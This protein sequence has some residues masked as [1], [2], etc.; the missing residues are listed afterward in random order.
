MAYPT[1]IDTDTP[2]SGTSLLSSPDHSNRHNVIG[3]A[4]INL[5]AK[6]GLGNGSAS[7]NRVLIGSGNGTSAWGTSVASFG[8]ANPIIGTPAITGG[9]ISGVTLIGPFNN[10]TYGTPAITGG[11]ITG[12]V[13]G[14]NSIKG[15]T[16]GTVL[17]QG[18]TANNQVVGSPSVTGGTLTGVA[19]NGGTLGTPV[20]SP[21]IYPVFAGTTITSSGTTASTS[22][23]ALP[24]GTVVITPNVASN[25]MVQFNGEWLNGGPNFNYMA[26]LKNGTIQAINIERAAIAAA[27]QIVSM[28]YIDPAVAAGVVG[29]YSIQYKV[30]GGTAT[31]VG[32]AVGGENSRLY[33]LAFPA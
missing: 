23:V 32:A 20:F 5:E 22:Y 13:L 25:I 4:V 30:D 15:G 26:I 2:S 31:I 11:T 10:G 12:A 1:S 24:G 29:T 7:I 3:S 16:V 28:T 18:G 14:T 6:V 33:A 8:L 21:S 17:I 9:T 19:I 27:Q